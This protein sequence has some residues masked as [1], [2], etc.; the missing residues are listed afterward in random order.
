[1]D[2]SRGDVPRSLWI[3]RAIEQAL[4]DAD[5]HGLEQ[6]IDALERTVDRLLKVTK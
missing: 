1:M 3:A 2:S 6:R 5:E 4:A